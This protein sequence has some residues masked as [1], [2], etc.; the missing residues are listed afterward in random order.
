MRAK[1][2]GSVVTG[3]PTGHPVRVLR[4]KLT[5]KFQLLEKEYSDLS[6]FEE[7]GRGCLPRAAVEGDIDMGSVM[8]GQIA[9]LICKQQSS[10]EIIEEMFFEANEIIK[11]IKEESL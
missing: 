10:L 8:A 1:D 3:R 9:G 2:I 11:R 6:K 5:R 7:L 4:N